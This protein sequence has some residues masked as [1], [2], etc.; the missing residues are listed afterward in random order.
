MLFEATSIR[1]RVRMGERGKT[2]PFLRTP[3]PLSHG[4]SSLC[5]TTESRKTTC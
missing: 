2:A 1:P 3:F 4:G 5:F